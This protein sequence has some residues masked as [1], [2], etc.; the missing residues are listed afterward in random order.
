MAKKTKK[1]M[2]TK[3]AQELS[4]LG[5]S[6]GGKAR[7]D[8]L[9]AEERS[10]IARKAVEARW[11][12]EG[13][14]KAIPR[15]TH[16]A[17]ILVGEAVIPCAVLK[18]GRRLLTQQGFLLAIGRARSAKGGQGASVDKMPAF[19]A[20]SNLKAFIGKEITASTRPVRFKTLSGAAAYGYVA[21]MLPQ[22]CRLYLAARD[23][24]V[25][26]PRQRPIAAQCYVLIQGLAT[27]GIVALVDE[28]TGYQRDRARDELAKILEAFV[29]KE[30]Q[31]WLSTFELEFYEL[32]CDLRGEPLARATKRPAYFGKLTNNLVYR[33]LAPGV[34]E[35][36]RELNPVTENGHRKRKHFQ[37]LTPDVGHSKLKEHLVGVTTAMKMA[38]YLGLDWSEFIKLLDKTHPKYHPMPLFEQLDD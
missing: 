8:A 38:K 24:G 9:T 1:A 7:A 18:D 17:E 21:E 37:H 26:T 15:A 10:A 20:A 30:I 29:A 13:R 36:L 34:L 19:L 31:K 5:A 27:V 11:E 22:V 6:K 16:E 2:T 12:R 23:A 32:I 35:K 28:A 33:R 25:L 3:H 4:K 14:L